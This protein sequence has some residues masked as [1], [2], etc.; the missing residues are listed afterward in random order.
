MDVYDAPEAQIVT[1][2]REAER[3]R[4]EPRARV[5]E[6]EAAPG[7]VAVA[8]L[9]RALSEEA[10]ADQAGATVLD[11]GMM[12]AEIMGR[13]RGIRRAVEMVAKRLAT[14]T[15][16]QEAAAE[17]L[18]LPIPGRIEHAA[19]AVFVVR[20]LIARWLKSPDESDEGRAWMLRNVARAAL[21]GI[22]ACDAKPGGGT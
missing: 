14:P 8:G 4:D 12:R 10:A 3:E 7:G 16:E 22:V 1:R 11:A 18:A 2:L 19:D 17:V 13:V 15:P 9:L 6:L 20:D 21:A 5:A